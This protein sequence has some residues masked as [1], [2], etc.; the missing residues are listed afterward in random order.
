VFSSFLLLPAPSCSQFQ[1]SLHCPCKGN[2]AEFPIFISLSGE[3]LVA[4]QLKISFRLA[5][6]IRFAAAPNV[7]ENFLDFLST[8]RIFS[9]GQVESAASAMGD[10]GKWVPPCGWQAP[11][12]VNFI[13]RI[14]P[15]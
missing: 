7:D 12:N 6:E 3:G 1:A 13:T 15:D 4:T 2:S 14:V 9:C 8:F 11:Q 5:R 10:G